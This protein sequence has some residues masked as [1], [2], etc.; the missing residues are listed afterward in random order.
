FLDTNGSNHAAHAVL[1]INFLKEVINK[2]I[3]PGSQLTRHLYRMESRLYRTCENL[4]L[5]PQPDAG[6]PQGGEDARPLG[7]G[8]AIKNPPKNPKKPP[9]N[10]D[11]N[12]H[13]FTKKL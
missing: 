11:I 12:Y 9:K 4:R 13:L 2:T 3:K 5:G 7:T 8:L 10:V 6:E 1:I